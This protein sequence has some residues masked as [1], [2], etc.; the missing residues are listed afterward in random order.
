MCD[1]HHRLFTR[2]YLQPFLAQYLNCFLWLH[3]Y[4][5]HLEVKTVALIT[6]VALQIAFGDFDWSLTARM[7]VVALRNRVSA[8]EHTRKPNQEM[9][10]MHHTSKSAADDS[11]TTMVLSPLS[12]FPPQSRDL[13]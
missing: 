5:W 2:H 9:Q 13:L 12:S 6:V 11:V 3:Y 10:Y 7:T 1:L 4:Q 8:G